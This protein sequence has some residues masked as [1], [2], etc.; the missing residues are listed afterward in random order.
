MDCLGWKIGGWKPDYRIPLPKLSAEEESLAVSAARRFVERTERRAAESAQQAEKEISRALCEECEEQG[1]K[2]DPDQEKYVARAAYLQ[3]YGLGFLE[4]LL[5]DFS[6]EEIA[7]VGIGQPVYVFVRGSG[8]KR[9]NVSVESQ[10]YFLSL[11]NRLGRG[12]GRRL[13]AQQPRMNAVL[14]DG[15]RLHAT[16]P[17]LSNCELTIRRFGS[18]PLSA[19]D[20]LSLG[21]Y[22]A[23]LLSLLSLAIQADLPVLFA[24]NTASGKTSSMNALLSFVPA[25]ERILLIEETPEISI[26]HPH[27]VRLIPFGEG[28]I[29]MVELVR[30]SL[31]M[32]P[33]RVVVGEVR[34]ADEARAFVESA[35]S[36]QAK[37]CYTTFHAQSSR[38]ALLRMRMMGCLEADL[39]G[40]GLF[41]VQRRVSQYDARKRAVSEA[42]KVTEVAIANRADPLHP[43][44]AYDGMRLLPSPCR[45]LLE[46]IAEG[47]GMGAGEASSEWKRRGKFF[48]G[49][50]RKAGFEKSF[51]II[52]EFLYGY[53]G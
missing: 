9:T 18:E 31:R 24:G 47:T 13:T 39:G 21:T 1:V 12:L 32:R 28:G 22:D 11:A 10:D 29:G 8:W 45:L 7:L 40:I 42:R 6:L 35:L 44:V 48:G 51:G 19:F 26:P 15:S 5:K 23:R 2:L 14:E 27:K 53:E 46:K 36:G 52:Q 4:E 49:K 50:R 37:G 20:L 33:D 41:I 34:G 43:I 16:M 30:D 25:S 3:T 38:D 17:P